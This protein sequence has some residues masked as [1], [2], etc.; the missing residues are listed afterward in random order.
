MNTG[1]DFMRP[2]RA[3]DHD[4]IDGLLRAAFAGPP[5]ATLVRDLRASG[6]I[7][8]E[9]VMP[10]PAGLVGYLAL[11]RM[12]APAGWLVLAPVAVAPA[13]QGKRLGTRMVTGILRL[14]AIKDMTTVVLGRPSFYAR[15]G[16]SQ[17]RA[18]LLTSPSRSE[19]MLIAR[20]GMDRP[21]EALVFPPTFAGI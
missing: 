7:E 15:A 18:E 5:E 14:M 8:L 10:W 1:P 17:E 20:P 9:M 3:T 4:A 19:T 13:W 11:S 6:E 21:T 16:F 2:A 12:V